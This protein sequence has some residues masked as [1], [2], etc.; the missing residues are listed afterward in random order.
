MS[1]GITKKKTPIP[2]TFDVTLS[3]SGLILFP[4]VV[5]V[6]VAFGSEQKSNHKECIGV[7]I[8]ISCPVLGLI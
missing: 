8:F 4:E 5:L 6:I 3:I 2:W 1:Q 7:G